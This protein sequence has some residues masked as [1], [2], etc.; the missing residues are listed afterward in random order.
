MDIDLRN[1]DIKTAHELMKSRKITAVKLAQAYLE[2]IELKNKDTNAYLEVYDDVLAQAKD[3]DKKF[4]DGTA[5]LITGIPI[6]LKDN[7][8]FKGKIS[9]AS[10]KILEHYRANYDSS[11]VARLRHKGAVFLGRTN[12]DEFAMGS[13]TETSAFGRTKNPI[14]LDYVPGGSS[15]GSAAAVAMDGALVSLGSDT[16]GSIRQPAAFCD[17]VGF[18][19]TYGF[20]SRY[21]LMSLASSLDQIGPIAKNVKDAFVLY[22][23][24]SFFDKQDANSISPEYTKDIKPRKIKKIGVPKDWINGEGVST[25]IKESFEKAVKILED[26]GYEI[27][28]I[29]LPMTEYSLAVYY[30]L[31]PAEASSNLS[32]YDGM[33][34]GR[35]KDGDTLFDIYAR[36]RGEGFGMETR[37]RV[38]LGTYILS[39]GY[40]DAYYRK[41]LDMQFAITKELED[42]F[43]KSNPDYVDVI[44]TPTSPF[45]PFRSGEKIDDP[46]AI[47][48]SDLFTVPANIAGVPAIS[49]PFERNKNDLP[50]GVQFMGPKYEDDALFEIA[51]DLESSIK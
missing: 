34:Y 50:M 45:P 31:M 26:K 44:F 35:R 17:L 21:G 27:V 49:I 20:V 2:N 19:P 38:L 1:L 3:A 14:N 16:G 8:L 9:S 18:K 41:A 39:H 13:S 47:K 10:S 37:R 28:N 29:S 51:E 42:V 30:I 40:Y 11:V 23:A 24:L 46:V 12:M 33:R 22:K 36:S 43:D 48:M 4:E 25:D 7:I 6:A 15:G 32:R 5:E